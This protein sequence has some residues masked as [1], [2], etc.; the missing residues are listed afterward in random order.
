MTLNV[1]FYECV[2]HPVER[3]LPKLLEK[4]YATHQKCLVLCKT[5]EQLEQID[6]ILWTYAQL[7]FLPH[8]SKQN[9]EDLKNLQPIWL[10]LEIDSPLH[11]GVLVNVS[12]TIITPSQV[13]QRILDIFSDA[14][15]AKERFD[16]YNRSGVLLQWFKQ[17][18]KGTWQKL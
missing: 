5:Q 3:V 1:T 13:T 18:S 17:D 6:N 11:E 8:G 4:I 2:T 14:S 12:E 15:K 9:M 10:S 7:A 16:V